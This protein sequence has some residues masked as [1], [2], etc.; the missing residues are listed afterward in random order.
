MQ[1]YNINLEGE[2]LVKEFNNYA[3]G[4]KGLKPIDSFNHGIDASRY[5]IQ[6]ILE[7]SVPKGMYIIK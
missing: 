5:A 4:V 7:R 3:W 1:D 6:Y 2:N